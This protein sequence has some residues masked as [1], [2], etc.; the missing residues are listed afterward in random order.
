MID[1]ASGESFVSGRPAL[2][3]RY[4]PMFADHPDLHCSLV[5]RIVAHPFVID[6]ERVVGLR[7]D[8]E[9]HAVAT[10]EVRK[11][12]IQRAWFLREDA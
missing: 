9:V 5:S 12:L 10:Y 2:I 8:A 6:E 4:G 7:P 3:E 11:G 1:L